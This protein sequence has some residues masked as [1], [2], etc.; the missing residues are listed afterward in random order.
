MGMRMRRSRG[1]RSCVRH[2]DNYKERRVDPEFKLL[3]NAKDTQ[4]GPTFAGMARPHQMELSA[5]A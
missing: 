5:E 4:H 2:R 1:L 3:L